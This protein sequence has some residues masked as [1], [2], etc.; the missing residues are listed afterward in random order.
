MMW[1]KKWFNNAS[2]ILCLLL[3]SGCGSVGP[4]VPPGEVGSTGEG[5]I[6]EVV[7]GKAV[8]RG[9]TVQTPIDSSPKVTDNIVPPP[10]ETSPSFEK[11]PDNPD[12]LNTT[13]YSTNQELIDAALE[14]CQASNNFWEKGD[15]DNAIN[16]LDKAYSLA[17]QINGSNVD[18]LQQK[19]DLRITISKRI[20]E[21][22]SSRFTVANG[23]HKAIPLDMNKYVKEALELF[24]GKE[25]GFFLEAYARSG[26]Y[27]P[28][29]VRALKE[30]GLPEELSWLPLIESGFKVRAMSKARALGMWQFIASTGFKFGLKRDTWIDE[31]MDPEKSTEAA[32]AYLTELHN[33]FGDWITVLAAYN[34]G[35]KR[36]LNLISTQKINYLDNFWDLYEKL[37]NETA[38][39]VPTFLAVLHI[40][41]NP[42]EHSFTL[43][44]LEKEI[45]Y[46][47]VTINKQVMIKTITEGLD[48]D[49]SDLKELNPELRQDFTP[50]TTYS[51]KVPKG[52]GELLLAKLDTI[53]E[54]NP[55]AATVAKYV[56]HRVRSGESLS[57]I[58]DR[59]K[60]S[61]KAIMDMNGLK[62]KDYLKVGRKLKIPTGKRYAS[63]EISTSSYQRVEKEPT[64]YVVKKGDSLFKIANRYHTTVN[65]IKALNRLES[66]NLQTGQVLIISSGLTPSKPGNTQ[67]YI[68]KEGD[69]PYLIAKTNQM[70][71]YEF[72]NLNNL[73]PES[74]IFPGQIVQVV[75]E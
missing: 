25:R 23:T 65:A 56:E 58:A 1:I 21:V 31:R 70:N 61:I 10:E 42:E 49:Y 71:L 20:I 44:P 26:R 2:L 19:E 72:L 39:Y 47:K 22:Y 53:P 38:G 67:E 48:I 69:S 64:E 24:K 74:T 60:T 41:N 51:L 55:P 35:E 36:V 18:V 17:L 3:Y 4:Y 12:S 50:K 9:D 68:V 66:S 8:V 27:R 14:Y 34:C 30:A 59:Y 45:E 32:I 75:V 16:A 33:I 52:M 7:E 37:P 29:I 57:L 43:P 6:K 40:L 54:Y 73:T 63:S 62:N 13:S 5:V 11:N 28:A 46:E 15:L